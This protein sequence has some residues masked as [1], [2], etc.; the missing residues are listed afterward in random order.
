[1]NGR[2]RRV[3]GSAVCLPP[4]LRAGAPGRPARR[5]GSRPPPLP[6]SS[7]PGTRRASR[8]ATPRLSASASVKRGSAHYSAPSSVSTAPARRAGPGQWAAAARPQLWAPQPLGP[9]GAGRA[10]DRPSR[11]E[12][13]SPAAGAG[14]CVPSSP[15]TGGPPPPQAQQ[16]PCAAGERPTPSST[17]DPGRREGGGGTGMRALGLDKSAER[18]WSRGTHRGDRQTGAPRPQTGVAL[19]RPPTPPDAAV[20]RQPQLPALEVGAATHGRPGGRSSPRQ[21][22][23]PSRPRPPDLSKPAPLFSGGAW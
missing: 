9:P 10:P 11:D 18:P 3:E 14:R 1:M 6:H 21:P 2:R 23:T 8:A 13:V 16:Y 12:P 17:V 4:C 19:R 20:P 5:P 15:A 7:P 22:R